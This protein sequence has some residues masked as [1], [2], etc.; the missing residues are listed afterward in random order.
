MPLPATATT[1]ERVAQAGARTFTA[2]VL[3]FLVLPMLVIVPLSFTAGAVLIYPVPGWSLRW[4]DDFFFNPLWTGALRNSLVI[5]SFTTVLA[6]SLGTVAA[7]GLNASRSRLR[8]LLFGLLVTPMVVPVVITA[9]ALF[10]LFSALGLS[11]T[12]PG[13]VLGHTVI[14]SPFA[15][16]TVSATLQGFDPNLPR[17][18][19]VLGAP[20]HV[21]FRRITLP[22]IWPGLL[23]GALFAFAASFDE[24]VISLFLSSPELRTLPR[25]IF[26]GISESISPTVAAAAVVL[27]FVSTG[28][29]LLVELLRRRTLRVRL[30]VVEGP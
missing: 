30:A 5:G 26:G 1:S 4:Y 25:Q 13:M 10:Y 29:M 21:V 20:P 15:F 9:V 7:L 11:G 8:P 16:I 3:A 2:L 17:A 24:L 14:A 6:T 19:A 23:S 12:L 18:A 22:L 27:A 28:L